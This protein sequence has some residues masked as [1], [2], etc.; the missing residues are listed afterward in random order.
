M[1][2]RMLVILLYLCACLSCV[3]VYAETETTTTTTTKDNAK[4]QYKYFYVVMSVKNCSK[5]LDKHEGFWIS[6]TT[7]AE[8]SK[9]NEEVYRQRSEAAFKTREFLNDCQ[10]AKLYLFKHFDQRRAARK[11]K[12][13]QKRTLAKG[14]DVH[15]W[16]LK[17]D[18]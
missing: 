7:K 4:T 8:S 10:D 5:S 6:T 1:M 16:A 2:Q 11:H 3:H 9:F 12:R 15:A 18:E 13:E 17:L 14:S